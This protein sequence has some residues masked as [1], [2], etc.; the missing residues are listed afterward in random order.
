MD[1][2]ITVHRPSSIVLRSNKISLASSANRPELA[3]PDR[4]QQVKWSHKFLALAVASALGLL[5][6]I[7]TSATSSAQGANVQVTDI[8]A[9]QVI[10]DVPLVPGK[11]TALRV[12]VNSSA[13]AGATV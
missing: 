8:K 5:A 2:T 3:M 7:A 13:P 9:V 6:T 10:E 12:F 11:A 4:R 1:S